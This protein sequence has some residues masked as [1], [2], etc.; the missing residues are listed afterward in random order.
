M[1]SYC[2]R[3]LGLPTHHRQLLPCPWPLPLAG[4]PR[5]AGP[6]FARAPHTQ[7]TQHTNI[8]ANAS[9][10]AVSLRPCGAG[11]SYSAVLAQ[12]SPYNYS[13]LARASRGG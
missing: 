5:G 12:K 13:V 3:E 9:Q 4:G 2:L 1:P 11:R 7:H 6:A 10:Y 8:A